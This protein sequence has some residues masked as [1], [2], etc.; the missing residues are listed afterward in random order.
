MSANRREVVIWAVFLLAFPLGM[1][2]TALAASGE[3]D[4]VTHP[5]SASGPDR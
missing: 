3:G 2:V 5:S 1:Q 4:R